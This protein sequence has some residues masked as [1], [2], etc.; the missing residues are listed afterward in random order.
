MFLTGEYDWDKGAPDKM[1]RAVLHLD[2]TGTVDG[3]ALF[4]HNG[5]HRKDAAID[6]VDLAAD[7]HDVLPA[8][9]ALRRR[10]RPRREGPLGPQPAARRRSTSRSSTRGS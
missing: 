10:H 3:Y 1:L 4:K 2:A 7:D 9:V 6:L 5:D 8:A